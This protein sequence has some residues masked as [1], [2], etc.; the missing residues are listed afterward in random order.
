VQLDERARTDRQMLESLKIRTGA[1][2]SVPLVTVASIEIGQGPSSIDRYDRQRR[3]VI[4]ADLI[5]TDALGKAIEK[6][7]E[8]PIVKN[9]PQGVV[10][11]QAGDA[12]VMG[13]IFGSFAYAMGAGLMMVYSVL[14][15]LFGSFLQPLTI[16]FSLPFSI[17]GAIFALLITGQPFSFPVVIGV[18]MLMG[19]VTKNAIMLVDFA[20]E[21]IAAGVKRYD[22][23]VDAGRKRARPI[24]MTTIAM[25]GGMLP[26]AMAI[27]SGG[28]FRAPMAIAVIG[29]LL[30]S[31]LLSL[32]FVPAVFVLMDDVGQWI[33]H[34]FSR[35]VGEVDEPGAA[36]PAGHAPAPEAA[37]PKTI[38]AE[39]DPIPAARA[40]E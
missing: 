13:E 36:T 37:K 2:A 34:F 22:A 31:T 28:E 4:G 32:I 9:L 16:L 1:G 21:E 38:E 14:V 3:I 5:G 10:L 12:E 33:W 35:F 24:V 23:I 20:I 11:K 27:G 29:G 8:L 26:S 18:L 25:A 40:A 6:V 30:L 17:G 19:V 39:P 15:L 7:M